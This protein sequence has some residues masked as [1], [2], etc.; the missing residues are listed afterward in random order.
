MMISIAVTT[1]LKVIPEESII[2]I[3]FVSIHSIPKYPSPDESIHWKVS[4]IS[5]SF[6]S[7]V[8]EIRTVISGFM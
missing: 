7:T 8:R 3:T 2:R 1:K 5:S 6:K 4:S